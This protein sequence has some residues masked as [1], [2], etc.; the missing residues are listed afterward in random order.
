VRPLKRDALIR[1]ARAKVTW[2]E[3]HEAVFRYLQAHGLGDMEAEDVLAELFGERAAQI[4]GDG[5]KRLAMGMVFLLCAAAGYFLH[6]E[7]AISHRPFSATLV[8]GAWGVWKFAH[9]FWTVL[10]A[11]KQGGEISNLTDD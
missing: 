7:G 3:S 10:G 9:G 2:G 8:L 5:F 1:D 4:R 6:R 11:R